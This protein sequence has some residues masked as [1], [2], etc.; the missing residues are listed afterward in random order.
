MPSENIS[1]PKDRV[2]LVEGRD[3]REVIYQFCNYHQIDNQKLFSVETQ[4]G[5]DN[6][7]ENLSV[8]PRT[9][10]EKVLAAII[11]ADV[12]IQARWDSV[13]AA[14]AK[15]DYTLPKMPNLE[16]TILAPPRPN[17]PRLGLWLMPDNQV[18]GMLEDFLLRLTQAGNVLLGR[19]EN[20]VDGISQAERLFGETQRSKAILHTWLAW[21]AEPG[22]PMGLAIKRQY[23]DP[24][25]NPAPEFKA[26]LED[27]F[28]PPQS[29]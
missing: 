8:R 24:D 26:W 16:G 1:P 27:L 12:D 28:M 22:T 13:C 15:C 6:L 3:D 29:P 10:E 4:E 19:A 14:L 25:Q 17:R 21:Q 11:D 23:L 5:I 20:A 7:L 18:E 2:L 9:G